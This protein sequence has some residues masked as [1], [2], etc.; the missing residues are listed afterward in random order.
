[1]MDYLFFWTEWSK[2]SRWTFQQTLEDEKR[3]KSWYVDHPEWVDRWADR[4]EPISR[5]IQWVLDRVHPRVT[6]VKIDPWDTWSMDHTLAGIVL[7]MLRQLKA[8]KHG[9][10]FV[11]DEDVPE[12]LRSTAAEPKENEWDID[13]NHFARW[14]WVLDE[15]IYAFEKKNQDDWNAEFHS[16]VPDMTWTPVDAEGKEVTRGE[17]RY[18]RMDQGAND[19][20]VFDEQGAKK[21]QDRI[22]NG[23]RLF[24]KYYE[25]LWD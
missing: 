7:P 25:G 19:T 23:F 9:A 20:H 10:P 14:D 16:G 21:V 5:G 18:F 24:G 13:D 3:E 12:H 1:M 22:S 8:I 2:C 11:D 17:H 6:Y 15:M 4:L